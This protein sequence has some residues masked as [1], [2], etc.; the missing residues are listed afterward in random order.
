MSDKFVNAKMAPSRLRVQAN[1]EERQLKRA[2]V[3]VK[4]TDLSG[5]DISPVVT[6]A[7]RL[8]GCCVTAAP[9]DHTAER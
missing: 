2:N 8:A 6:D 7:G 1:S 9:L 4:A 3:H 5:I